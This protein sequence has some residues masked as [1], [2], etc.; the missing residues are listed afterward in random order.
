MSRGFLSRPMQQAHADGLLDFGTTIFD[1]G[2]GKGD[3]IR[4]LKTLGLDAIG[5]DP[6]HA[7][8]TELRRSDLVN[9]GYVVN[10]IEDKLERSDAL[11]KAWRLAANVLVVSARLDWDQD[12][13]SGKSY[14]DGRLMS[15]GAFQKFYSQEELRSWIEKE[16]RVKP[17]NSVLP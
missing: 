11:Q 16:L 10:V 5:W 12:S 2:C 1:Y 15:N 7:T 4:Q 13:K 17:T 8:E 14:G 6:A 9:I 3:D